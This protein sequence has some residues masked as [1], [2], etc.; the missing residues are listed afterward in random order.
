MGTKEYKL[1]HAELVFLLNAVENV[2]AELEQVEL[3]HLWFISDSGEKI[4]SALEILRGHLGIKESEDY[5]EC[6]E[7]EQTTLKLL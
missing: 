6:E 3:D 4:A 2:W 7:P 1:T 5:G